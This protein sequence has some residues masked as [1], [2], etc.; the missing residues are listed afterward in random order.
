VTERR[1]DMGVGGQCLCPKC[2]TKIPHERGIPCQD[3]KCPRCGTK[4][5]REGSYHHQLFEQKKK[6][7]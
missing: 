7:N 5:L 3:M 1:H 2:E 6:K 4:M